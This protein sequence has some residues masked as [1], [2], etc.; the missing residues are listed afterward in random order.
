MLIVIVLAEGMGNLPRISSAYFLFD[1]KNQEFQRP[2][3]ELLANPIGLTYSNLR[4]FAESIYYYYT[5]PLFVTGLLAFVIL[6][7]KKPKTAILLLLLW[8]IP[9]GIFAAVGRIIFSRYIL[10]TVPYFLLALAF[11]FDWAF[12]QKQKVLTLA[13]ICILLCILVLPLK[14]AFFIITDP[15]RVALPPTDYSQ[16]IAD[17]SSG[18]GLEEV[19]QVIDSELAKGNVTIVTQGTF[20][21]YPYAFNL[22]YWN[23]PHVTILPRWPLNVQEPQIIEANKASKTLIIL[24]DYTA[25]PPEMPVTQ[26]IRADKPCGSNHPIFVTTLKQT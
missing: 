15:T 25:I 9:I 12:A 18:Y 2:L 24:K 19:Y 23:N 3:Q 21:I 4:A 8:A 22:R 10:L 13:T 5:L 6:L 11:A 26:V 7:W 17:H 20:G 14:S 1:R 16:Y